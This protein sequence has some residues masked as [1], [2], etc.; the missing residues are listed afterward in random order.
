[1]PARQRNI[2]AQWNREVEDL[3]HV[4]TLGKCFVL[5]SVMARGILTAVTWFS[6]PRIPPRVVAST[7]EALAWSFDI[8]EAAGVAVA[9]T[10][11]RDC[12]AHLVV[13]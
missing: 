12:S 4:T 11:R 1:M 9:E 7:N 6:P 10:Q 3:E 8:C 2:Q 5:R 13:G